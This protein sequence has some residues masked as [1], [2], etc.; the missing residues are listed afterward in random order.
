MTTPAQDDSTPKP[1]KF[2]LRSR[3]FSLTYKSHV[4]KKSLLH[5][6]SGVMDLRR[7]RIWFE[8]SP[9]GYHHTHGIFWAKKQPNFKDPT[10]FDTVD[11]ADKPLHPHIK[12]INTDQHWKNC[13]R[14]NKNKS[15][16]AEGSDCP[17]DEHPLENFTNEASSTT[18]VQIDTILG[19]RSLTHVMFSEET[20]GIYKERRYWAKEIFLSKRRDRSKPPEVYCF[21]GQPRS[22]KS[23]H[24]WDTWGG[25]NDQD[26]DTITISG[27]HFIVG[28]RGRKCAIFED[29]EPKCCRA[30]LILKLTDRYP[31]TIDVK[32]GEVEWSPDVICFTS[33]TNPIT[34]YEHPG[35]EEAF[36]G[37]CKQIKKLHRG[38]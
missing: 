12:P 11:V 2:N 10:L 7:Y 4:A 13:C 38:L 17:P 20:S 9:S 31:F 8:V 6:V 19:K 23:K 16:K 22:G 3:R 26:M 32:G 34:W 15:D 28:Y 30:T 37:R 14:Y 21:W 33:N 18:T 35:W 36:R 25:P 24:C 5:L 1:K 27:G 29:F